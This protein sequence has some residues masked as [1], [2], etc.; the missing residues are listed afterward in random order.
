MY[1]NIK[2]HWVAEELKNWFTSYLLSP[3]NPPTKKPGEFGYEVGTTKGTLI[4]FELRLHFWKFREVETVVVTC[5]Q[6]FFLF[7]PPFVLQ[8]PKRT[9]DHRL[10]LWRPHFLFSFSS[11][12]VPKLS[13]LL[14]ERGCLTTMFFKAEKTF[15]ISLHKKQTNKQQN[16]DTSFTEFFEVQKQTVIV[17]GGIDGYFVF[18]QLQR[19][20]VSGKVF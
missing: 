17:N 6:A 16:S 1:P 3:N 5:D 7:S 9:P 13:L 12:L 20:Q 4:S 19:V 15:S 18:I 8:P 10:Q 2:R 11:S 14:R